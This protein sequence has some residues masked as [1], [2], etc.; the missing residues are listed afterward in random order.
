MK[1]PPKIDISKYE[2]TEIITDWEKGYNAAI[3]AVKKMN[4]SLS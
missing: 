4:S 2:G 3:E 1:Y